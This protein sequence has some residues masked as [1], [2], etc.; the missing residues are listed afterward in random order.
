MQT[1]DFV[2]QIKTAVCCF[3]VHSCAEGAMWTSEPCGVNWYARKQHLR[4]QS[5]PDCA[6]NSV[7]DVSLAERQHEHGSL[8]ASHSSGINDNYIKTPVLTCGSRWTSNGK[9]MNKRYELLLMSLCKQKVA[10]ARF[11]LYLSVVREAVWFY[12]TAIQ[13][14]LCEC[15]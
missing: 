8:T 13:S 10:P 4:S 14:R 11:N 7:V 3:V 1:Y 15:E 2:T 5:E 12:D 6:C 9:Q